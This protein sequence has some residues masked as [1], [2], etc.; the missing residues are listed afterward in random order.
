[1]DITAE[2]LHML[3]TCVEHG[4]IEIEDRDEQPKPRGE[5]LASNSLRELITGPKGNRFP[6]PKRHKGFK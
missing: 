2:D 6:S 5:F 3:E 1:M 4:I